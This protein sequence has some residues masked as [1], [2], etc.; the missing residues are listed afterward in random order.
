MLSNFS[1]KI[2]A[3]FLVAIVVA[4]VLLQWLPLVNGIGLLGVA[5][6]ASF[7]RKEDVSQKLKAGFFLLLVPLAFWVATFEPEGFDYPVVFSLA[8]ESEGAARYVFDVNFAKALCGF[9]LVYLLWPTLRQGEFV[10][11]ARYA[12]LVALLAPALVIAVAV[13]VLGLQLQPKAIEQMLLFALGNLLIVCIAEEAFLRFLF[14]QPL[15]NLIANMTANRSLQELI[16]LVVVTGVFVAIHS[17]LSG[18]AIW[19][20]GFAGFLYGLSYTLSKNIAYPM[21]IHFFVNQIHFSFLTYPV[22]LP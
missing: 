4:L 21:V 10:A 17:G 1:K 20:Y 2:A 16:P 9:L 11:R 22:P 15:R 3:G 18:A 7:A 6:L 19:I 13:P 8:G 12:F 5:G 14:Q